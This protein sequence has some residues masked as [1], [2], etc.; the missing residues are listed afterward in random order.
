M[1][2]ISYAVTIKN[3]ANRLIKKPTQAD[4]DKLSPL[5]TCGCQGQKLHKLYL[6]GAKSS[7]DY[8]AIT[9]ALKSSWVD[10]NN[11]EIMC[12]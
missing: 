7:L 11:G 2:K 5:K 9:K 3:M 10:S 1:S 4:I 8:A 6:N 12:F